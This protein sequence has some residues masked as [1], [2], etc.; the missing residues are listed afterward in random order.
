MPLVGGFGCLELVLY[1]I[2][3]LA[4][5]HYEPLISLQSEMKYSSCRN[6]DCHHC[7]C[8]CGDNF[9]PS[10]TR[11][12][13]SAYLQHPGHKSYQHLALRPLSNASQTW[14]R[15]YRG[16]NLG[17]ILL[18]PNDQNMPTL[19]LQPFSTTA[20]RS[21]N[22]KWHTAFKAFRTMYWNGDRLMP[23]G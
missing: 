18:L 12:A 17:P 8:Y 16:T 14:L 21:V 11:L 9:L 22:Q 19:G 10:L 13:Y 2:R 1:C 4:Q 3:E 5:Q 6:I 23:V 7:Q 15:N 20:E